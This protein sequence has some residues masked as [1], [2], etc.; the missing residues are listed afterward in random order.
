MCSRYDLDKLKGRILEVIPKQCVGFYSFVKVFPDDYG[1]FELIK[2]KI[3]REYVEALVTS[4]MESTGNIFRGMLSEDGG[5]IKRIV[6]RLSEDEV[7]EM[8]RERAKDL[9]C[10][11]I[12]Y[13][14]R[15]FPYLQAHVQ[16]ATENETHW[17]SR[18]LDTL[19]DI[20]AGK[21]IDKAEIKG[22]KRYFG[23]MDQSFEKLARMAGIRLP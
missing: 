20:S 16:C 1:S 18:N 23:S 19:F 9:F 7:I 4:T 5:D 3:V 12:T 22:L 8:V 13:M 15:D 10:G 21:E 14:R 11:K 17:L 2:D 6:R